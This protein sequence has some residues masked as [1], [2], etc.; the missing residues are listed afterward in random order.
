MQSD[1]QIGSY[2]A[3]IDDVKRHIASGTAPEQIAILAPKHRFLE[4]FVPYATEAGVGVSYERRQD[5][6]QE[7][8]IYELC[9]LAE[10]I[11]G[12]S[13]QRYSEVNSKMPELLSF[14]WWQLDAAL[15]WDISIAAHRSKLS[16]LEA[17]QQSE[18]QRI[19]AVAQWLIK[20]AT[21]A[22]IL[23]LESMLDQLIGI[24]QD[25]AAE[26]FTR[27]PYYEYYFVRPPIEKEFSYFMTSLISIRR[28]VRNYASDNALMLADFVQYISLRRQTS[29]PIINDHPLTTAGHSIHL[30]TAHKSKG[31]EFDIVYILDAA[32][33]VWAKSRG[34]PNLISVPPHIAT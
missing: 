10:V 23:P 3:V 2:H 12:L 8:H 14:A 19:V 13:D 15:L 22:R 33:G 21:D 20:Q 31:L 7:R 6:L 5:V 26:Y 28:H 9:F 1:T 27:A 18:H 25:G 17:M 34:R 24:N 30:M 16:W 32:Q 4:R 11:A 29:L